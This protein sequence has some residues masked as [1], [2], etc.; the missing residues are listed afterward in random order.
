MVAAEAFFVC[1]DATSGKEAHFSNLYNLLKSSRMHG[2][3][4]QFVAVATKAGVL[5]LL[6]LPVIRDMVF[7]NSN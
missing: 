6:I 4:R 3:H 7:D 2:F 5:P 1:A